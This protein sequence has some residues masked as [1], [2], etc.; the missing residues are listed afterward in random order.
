MIFDYYIEKI[1]T[2]QKS[3]VSLRTEQ[4]LED[5]RR[6]IDTLEKTTKEL[7]AKILSRSLHVCEKD[8]LLQQEKES[9]D[10]NLVHKA[11]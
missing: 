8:L 1:F 11:P 5:E 7:K 6:L 2:L 10:A 3:I 4:P 9:G